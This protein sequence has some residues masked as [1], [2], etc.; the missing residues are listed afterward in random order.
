MHQDASQVM[1]EHDGRDWRELVL[2][3]AVDDILPGVTWGRFEEVFSPAFWA[4]QAWLHAPGR[5]FESY[6]LGRTLR[7]EMAACLLGGYGISAEVGLAA[8]ESVRARGL[9]AGKPSAR[10]LDEALS[11]TL[12]IGARS[13]RYRFARQKSQYLADALAR[14][15]DVPSDARGRRLRDLLATFRGIGPKTASWITRNWCDADDVAILDVHVC[16]ACEQAGVFA[17]RMDPAR[18]YYELESRF[19]QFAEALK[20]RASVLDNLIWNMMRRLSP[21]ILR[22]QPAARE[23]A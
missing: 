14:I 2:P 17:S 5:R 6:R 18:H 19:L 9:L 8:F 21:A 1:R 11:S 7:E 16:R 13:V 20:V 10:E 3:P 15:D 23:R 12:T 4:G 22:M